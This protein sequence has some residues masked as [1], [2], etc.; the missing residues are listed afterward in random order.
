MLLAPFLDQTYVIQCFGIKAILKILLNGK[1][2]VQNRID[3]LPIPLAVQSDR[4]QNR[5]EQ[6]LLDGLIFV[7]T[8]QTVPLVH[9]QVL[10]EVQIL[11]PIR[12]HGTADQLAFQLGQLSF[13]QAAREFPPRVCHFSM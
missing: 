12:Q 11:D 1:H 6:I 5:L 4:A 13:V 3:R 10:M 9:D 2:D 7:N 8:V